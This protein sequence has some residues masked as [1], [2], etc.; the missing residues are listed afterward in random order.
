MEEI[1]FGEIMPVLKKRLDERLNKARIYP[2][3]LHACLPA[4]RRLKAFRTLERNKAMLYL[5]NK[6]S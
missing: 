3:L 4:A 5:L 1:R 2:E 6:K